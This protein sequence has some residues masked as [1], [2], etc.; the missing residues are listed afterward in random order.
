LRK[1]RQLCLPSYIFQ[2]FVDAMVALIE[3]VIW[4]RGI[5]DIVESL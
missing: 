5:N 1:S 3:D 2:F 4:V